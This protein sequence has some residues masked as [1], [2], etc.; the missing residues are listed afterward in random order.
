MRVRLVGF[1]ITLAFP[2]LDT[3]RCL[4]R[5]ENPT[6]PADETAPSAAVQPSSTNNTVPDT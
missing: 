4:R 1:R 6:T 5:G 2:Y 3:N